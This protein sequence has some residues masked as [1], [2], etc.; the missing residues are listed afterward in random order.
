MLDMVKL[1]NNLLNTK[2]TI[3]FLH[4][5][6]LFLLQFSVEVMLPRKSPAG[7]KTINFLERPKHEKFYVIHCEI[8]P[9][10]KLNNFLPLTY[11]FCSLGLSLYRVDFALTVRNAIPLPKSSI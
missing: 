9:L 8:L 1:K 6:K 3:F 11:I 10:W 7:H 5:F 2:V 4:G